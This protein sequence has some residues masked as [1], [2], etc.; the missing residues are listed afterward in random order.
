MGRAADY[1]ESR[2]DYDKPV[3]SSGV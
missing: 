2:V 3:I 1:V